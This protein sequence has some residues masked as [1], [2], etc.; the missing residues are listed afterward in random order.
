[1]AK[2][3]HGQAD[4]ILLVPFLDILCSLIGVLILIIVVMVVAQ[5][6]QATGRPVEEVQRSIAYKQLLKQQKELQRIEQTAKDLA[7]KTEEEKKDLEEKEAKVVRLRKLLSSSADVQ[8]TNQDLSMNL[9]KELDNLLLEIDGHKNQQAE[10]K[11]QIAELNKE[12]IKRKPPEKAETPPVVV[13][14]AGSGGAKDAKLFF[15]EAGAGKIVIF[16]DEEK[17]TQV[18]AAPEV[19]IADK[20]YEHF[21]TTVKS[22]PNAKIVYLIRSDGGPAY[23]NA[24][25]W[26]METYKLDVG[27]IGRLPIP[28]T[29]KIDLKEFKKVLGTMPPPPEAQLLPPAGAPAPVTPA[30]KPAAPAAKPTAPPP[31]KPAAPAATKPAAP[32]KA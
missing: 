7:A 28:G 13:Q 24:A 8:K 17:R 11:K 1:M 15:V 14:P 4:E 26:A 29:G 32:T 22:V 2:R 21:L 30:A 9:V 12:I 6:Q 23:N 19:I 31:A 18:S 25:G 3:R 27:Q 5:S 16:W 20:A 10:L